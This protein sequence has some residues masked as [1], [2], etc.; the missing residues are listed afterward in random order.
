MKACMEVRCRIPT[1]G[2]SMLDTYDKILGLYASTR[3]AFSG[4]CVPLENTGEDEYFVL[5]Q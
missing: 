4:F 3:S 1:V 2:V 5:S